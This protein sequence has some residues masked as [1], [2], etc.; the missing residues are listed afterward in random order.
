MRLDYHNRVQHAACA[1]LP[2]AFAAAVVAILAG[3]SAAPQRAKEWAGPDSLAS[4]RM[5]RA[6]TNGRAVEAQTRIAEQL[7][8]QPQNGYLH[9]LNGLAYDLEGDTPQQRDLAAVGYDAAVRFAPGYYWAHYLAGLSSLRQGE[10]ANAAEQFTAAILRDP[11]NPYAFAG[12]AAAAYY[13]GDLEVAVRAGER[14]LALSPDDPLVMRTAAFLA[15]ARGDSSA[16]SALLARA[17]RTPIAAREFH[18]QQPRLAQ[19]LNTA[20]VEAQLTPTPPAPEVPAD[21]AAPGQVMV[22]VTLLLSQNGTTRNVGINLLDG[23]SLEFSGER[24][25]VR[26]S[27]TTQSQPTTQLS[28]TTTLSVPQVT[29]SLNLFNT[30]DDYYQVIARPSLVASVGQPSE[31]FVGRNVTVGVSGINLGSLQPIDIGTAV[32]ITPESITNEKAKFRIE[33]TRSFVEQETNGSFQQ[34]LTT[35]KQSVAATIEVE[36]GKTMILSSLYEGV[37]VGSGSKT[38]GLG[39]VPLIN[40]L[41][42][43]RTATERRDAALILVTPRIP[44]KIDTDTRVFRPETLQRLLDLWNKFIEPVG[45]IDNSARILGSKSKYFQPQAGDLRL[46]DLRDPKLLARV[47]GDTMAR[48]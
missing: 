38:P 30:R 10:N 41:F 32:K 9:L 20:A 26:Q 27:A 21:P 16:L 4:Q 45:G 47:V 48:L 22:E 18:A 13:G 15:A 28:L 2:I 43:S 11:Q 35:F 5:L 19:L 6:L 37:N 8:S 31:F 3:C 17:A 33:T 29:Y 39:D 7:R 44:G 34:S 36:F 46:P 24:Q 23:L 42:R 14:A 40:S 12:L 25:T 1:R